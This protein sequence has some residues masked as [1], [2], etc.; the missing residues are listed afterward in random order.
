MCAQ[1]I[2]K[3]KIRAMERSLG[4][5]LLSHHPSEQDGEYDL[6]VLPFWKSPVITSGAANQWH[7]QDMQFSLLPSWSKVRKPKF[8]TYNARIESITEKPTWRGPFERNHCLVPITGFI[9]AVYEGPYQGNMIQFS[10]DQ[11]EILWAAGIFDKWQDIQT[12]EFV[13]S[14]AILTDEPPKF[15]AEA[16][17]DRCPIF[18]SNKAWN[19]WIFNNAQDNKQRL[20]ILKEGRASPQFEVH[21]DRP[22]KQKKKNSP[23]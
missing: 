18:L 8:A 14:F 3:A 5:P 11:G 13:E 17:H 4:R 20:A 2:I 19:S 12:G 6:R 1:Y 15:I 7:L 22:L 9:E 21:V 10:G 16:G 23:L